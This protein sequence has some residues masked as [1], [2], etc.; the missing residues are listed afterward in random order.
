[1][2]KLMHEQKIR[3]A[4]FYDGESLIP[5]PDIIRFFAK[6]KQILTNCC[7]YL[8]SSVDNFVVLD[9]EPDCDE[10]L[11]QQFLN[12]PYIYGERSLSGKGYH[13]VYPLPDWLSDYPAAEGKTV[14]KDKKRDFEILMCHYCTFTGNSIPPAAQTTSDF[15]DRTFKELAAIQEVKEKRQIELTDIERPDYPYSD[16]ILELLE[17]AARTWM[18]ME[19]KRPFLNK[20]GTRDHSAYEFAMI[21]YLYKKYKSIMQTDVIKANPYPFTDNH[22]AWFIY[23]AVRNTLPERPKHNTERNGM[24]Y[25][26][27]SVKRLM[28]LSEEN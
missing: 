13:L 3:G 23:E 14:I 24:P 21:G 16:R 10:S 5:L 6:H 19:H 9:I 11:K 25:L 15:F 1:M 26:L 7:Y 8:H 27:Y 17:Y 12:T 18:D 22:T 2:Y 4:S 20:N 28:E